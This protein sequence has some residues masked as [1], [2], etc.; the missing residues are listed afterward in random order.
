MRILR[1]E[2]VVDLDLDSEEETLE[3]RV[4][5]AEKD[6]LVDLLSNST[7][8]PGDREEYEADLGLKGGEE[9]ESRAEGGGKDEHEKE[10]TSFSSS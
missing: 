4:S 10:S 2:N 6:A 5:L 9:P 1:G 8:F 7:L 3:D